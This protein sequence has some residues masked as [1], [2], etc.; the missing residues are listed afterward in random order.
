MAN[1]LPGKQYVYDGQI[2]VDGEIPA[3]IEQRDK[4]LKMHSPGYKAVS[5]DTVLN[6][7][8]QENRELF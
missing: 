6:G 1:L 7:N 5:F 3:G 8:K 4:I 2:R